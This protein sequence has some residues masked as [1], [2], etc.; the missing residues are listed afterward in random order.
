MD[1]SAPHANSLHPSLNDLI[2]KEEY[3]LTYVTIDCAI[4]ITRKQRIGSNFCNVDSRDA[5]K[6]IPVQ[7]LWPFRGI[8]WDDM[9]YLYTGL[10]FG[11]RSS[12]KCVDCLSQAICWILKN[13]YGVKHYLHLLDDFL[14]INGPT[15]DADGTMAILRFVFARLGIPLSPTKTME[16]VTV[17]EYLG[18]ILDRVKMEARLPLEK[19]KRNADL[20]QAFSTKKSCNKGAAKSSGTSQFCMPGDLSGRAF[21]SY[22]VTMVCTSGRQATRAVCSRFPAP[23]E[24]EREGKH[25]W[26][27]SVFP[28][29]RS[30]SQRFMQCF[31]Q[32][33]TLSGGNTW[34][35][36]LP[37]VSEVLLIYL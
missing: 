32:F 23:A 2:N 14:T 31:V 36:D 10:V 30:V 19:I 27:A 6:Q 18:I 20:L 22:I 17:I 5:F 37:S 33:L 24:L 26:S 16:T 13:N 25:L 35:A 8:K 12:P 21:M 9:Y 7:K 15:E 34:Q 28:T 4:Y 1:F 11:S 29:T 3:S